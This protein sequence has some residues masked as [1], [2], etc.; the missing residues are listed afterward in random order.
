MP[1]RKHTHPIPPRLDVT[2]YKGQWLKG[3]WLALH[4]K[5]H[6][7]VSHAR[8][9][10]VVEEVAKRRGILKPKPPFLSRALVRRLL[11]RCRQMIYR[12]I[13]FSIS[14]LCTFTRRGNRLSVSAKKNPCRRGRDLQRW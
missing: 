7:I 14:P 6:A 4:P 1:T 3:Q 13:S 8:S 5:T 11:R 2:A 9:L 10:E 12:L